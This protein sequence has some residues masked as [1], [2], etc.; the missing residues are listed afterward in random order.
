MSALLSSAL[1]ALAALYN[2]N[3]RSVPIISAS[4][5]RPRS[6]HTVLRSLHGDKITA[7]LVQKLC[8]TSALSLLLGSDR[9]SKQQ[10]GAAARPLPTPGPVFIF[11]TVRLQGF[12]QVRTSRQR[13][14]KA[15]PTTVRKAG[16]GKLQ[17]VLDCLPGKAAHR[18]DVCHRGVVT[19]LG[20]DSSL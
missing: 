5:P 2:A 4:A 9:R 11:D 15:L 12:M 14:S 20:S 6:H 3:R 8:A 16:I 10:S 18:A 17:V 1:P 7:A 19:S 13:L